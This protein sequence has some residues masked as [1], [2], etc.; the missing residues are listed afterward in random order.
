MFLCLYIISG[1]LLLCM[2]NLQI[3]PL[4]HKLNPIYHLLALLGGHPILH[5]SGVRVNKMETFI[6]VIVTKNQ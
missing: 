2:I 5:V 1:S 6:Q 3:N 4:N